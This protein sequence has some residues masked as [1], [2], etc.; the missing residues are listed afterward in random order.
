MKKLWLIKK[1]NIKNI[2]REYLFGP[3]TERVRTTIE[4]RISAFLNG[5]FTFSP[6]GGGTFRVRCNDSTIN[7]AEIIAQ[8]KLAVV[9]QL[10][11]PPSTE[12][13]ILNVI[14]SDGTT[15]YDVTIV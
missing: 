12:S 2:L 11:I 6:A 15:I 9:I 13:I 3:N 10:T 14:N 4:T 1:R 7:T 5:L 8:G